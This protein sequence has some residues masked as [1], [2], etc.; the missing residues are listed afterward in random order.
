MQLW[1]IDFLSIEKHTILIVLLTYSIVKM[2]QFSMSFFFFA[3]MRPFY[4]QSFDIAGHV[5]FQSTP[6]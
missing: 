6:L 2:L 4:S 5:V 3:L 1:I